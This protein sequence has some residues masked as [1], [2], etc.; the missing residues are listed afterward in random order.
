MLTY[1]DFMQ[2]AHWLEFKDYG[3]INSE[4]EYKG[5]VFNEMKGHMAN[6]DSLF[7]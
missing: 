7:M 5:V 3:N 4:L 2:E 6:V 1:E